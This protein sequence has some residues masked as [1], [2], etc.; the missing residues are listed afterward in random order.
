MHPS[1]VKAVTKI[2]VEEPWAFQDLFFQGNLVYTGGRMHSIED[3]FTAKQRHCL[4]V[5]LCSVK[6]LKVENTQTSLENHIQVC[7]TYS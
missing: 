7:G 6:L 1:Y 4:G 2:K 5:T 3:S